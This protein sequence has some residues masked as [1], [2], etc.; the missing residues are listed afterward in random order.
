MKNK[1]IVYKK[2]SDNKI[3]RIPYWPGQAIYT[4][5]A[6]NL[7][8]KHLACL[9]PNASM[10]SSKS[11]S[12]SLS[13]FIQ[14]ILYSDQTAAL[15]TLMNEGHFWS[16]AASKMISL[17][18]T[19]GYHQTHG[20]LLGSLIFPLFYYLVHVLLA[21]TFF[22]C[23]SLFDIQAESQEFITKIEIHIIW[24]YRVVS[25]P[26]YGKKRTTRD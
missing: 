1:F 22:F 14:R 25:T 8:S 18:T 17:S 16:L 21:E 3:V 26:V 12:H 4:F 10:I 19:V 9:T 13:F 5:T 24:I 11:T 15:V 20:H 2:Q 23:M 6:G 7:T